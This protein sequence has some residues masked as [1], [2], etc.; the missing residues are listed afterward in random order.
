LH[1]PA[2]EARDQRIAD[3][4]VSRRAEEVERSQF[5]KH[6]AF[7]TEDADRLDEAAKL[8]RLT[9]R[10]RATDDGSSARLPEILRFADAFQ[11]VG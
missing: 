3:R 10:L 1:A 4:N 2:I 11:C 5:S 9:E 8:L 6:L 7:L